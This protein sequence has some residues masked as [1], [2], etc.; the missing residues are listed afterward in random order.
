MN[1]SLHR[2]RGLSPGDAKCPERNGNLTVGDVRQD[3]P[4]TE[5][6]ETIRPEL[7]NC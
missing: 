6:V 4:T 5:Y 2:N 7:W 1:L 3:F